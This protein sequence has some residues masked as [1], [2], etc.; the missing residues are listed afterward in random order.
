M[1]MSVSYGQG[2]NKGPQAILEASEQLETFDEETQFEPINAGVHL[3]DSIDTETTNPEAIISKLSSAVSACI[4]DSK[5]PVVLGGEHSL[6]Y[7]TF[8]GVS[9]NIK[10]FTV[11]HFDAHLDLRST[12]WD[13]PYSHA[14]VMR[15]IKETKF[16]DI[17]SLGIRSVSPEEAEYLNENPH[18]VYYARDIYSGINA[19]KYY[20]L[21]LIMFI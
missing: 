1:E 8:D 5:I 6:S 13:S 7:G 15:R 14:C 18:T 9:Q 12:Y 3:M 2:T 4:N 16:N 17:I 19:E 10:D 20:L 21:F 11:L